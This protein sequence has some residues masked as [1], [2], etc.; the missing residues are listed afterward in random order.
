VAIDTF[1]KLKAEVSAYLNRSDIS[2]AQI[3]NFIS[4]AE[5]SFDRV[6]RVRDQIKRSTA[7]IST[8][9]IGLP[10][11]LLELFNI[12]LNTNPVTGLEQVSLSYA[13]Q[14]KPTL[15]STG[16]PRYYT[17]SGEQ[18]EF[19]PTPDA[20]YE[21]EIVYYAQISRLSAD[22]TAS[23]LLSK[24]PDLYLMATLSQAEPFLM[25]DERI[26][27]WNSFLEKGLEEL[28]LAD[29][30]AQTNT[31]TIMMRPTKPLDDGDWF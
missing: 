11:D 9:Y 15:P 26:G 17:I 25:N 31:G 20:T 3:E 7:S 5:A 21:I 27:V 16:K 30:K 22:N 18:I 10:S 6:I 13:D 2:D 23:W 24:H 14:V 1:A 12:Q 29:E 4:L 8:Q 28:R 19:L